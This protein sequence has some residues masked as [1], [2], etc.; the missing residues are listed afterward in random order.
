MHVVECNDR[1]H[2]NNIIM[3]MKAS[4]VT[5]LTIVYSTVYSDADQSKHKSSASLAFV[6]GEFSAQMA[7]NAENVSIS[8]RQYDHDSNASWLL[9]HCPPQKHEEKRDYFLAKLLFTSICGF[10]PAY[11]CSQIVTNFDVNCFNTRGTGGMFTSQNEKSASTK[12]FF[13]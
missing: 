9:T 8:W 5:S 4:Q 3:G 13:L 10:T 1:Y 7:S 6:R 12:I 2:Y 11:L